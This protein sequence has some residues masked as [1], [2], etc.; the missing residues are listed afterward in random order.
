MAYDPTKT[1][2]VNALA[3]SLALDALTAD[4]DA[5]DAALISLAARVTLL[6]RGTPMPSPAPTPTPPAG[7][8]APTHSRVLIGANY[9][10]GASGQAGDAYNF[11]YWYDDVPLL[12]KLYAAG[13]RSIRFV[14]QL[15]RV[16]PVIGGPADPQQLAD[17][18]RIVD[19][20]IALGMEVKVDDHTYGD[21]YADTVRY[22][23]AAGWVAAFEAVWSKWKNV[24][25]FVCQL[26]TNE[27][28][29]SSIGDNRAFQHKCRSLLRAK[30]WGNVMI[31][32]GTSDYSS[33]QFWLRRG[34]DQWMVE[35]DAWD[36]LGRKKTRFEA[37]QYPVGY[38]DQP[39]YEGNWSDRY[40]NWLHSLNANDI[41]GYLGEF[42][43]YQFPQSAQMARDMVAYFEQFPNLRGA[44]VFVLTRATIVPNQALGAMDNAGTITQLPLLELLDTQRALTAPV[45][46]AA[47]IDSF[48][49]TPRAV[50]AV[51]TPFALKVTS[52][53]SD[54]LFVSDFDN[55]TPGNLA[56]VISPTGDKFE[57]NEDGT[58]CYGTF[59][60]IA[61]E[62]N[63][64]LIKMMGDQEVES[65]AKVTVTAAL[66]DLTVSPQTTQRGAYS[67]SVAGLRRGS[68]VETD[69][70]GFS[71][72]DGRLEG[73]FPDAGV[74][75]VRLIERNA[76]GTTPSKV[77]EVSVNVL[78]AA[79]TVTQDM[80]FFRETEPY[81]Q[82]GSFFD[83]PLKK[84]PNIF[85]LWGSGAQI[86]NSYL[87]IAGQ[88]GGYAALTVPAESND[89]MR[90]HTVS[91]PADGNYEIK[92]DSGSGQ[93]GPRIDKVL[94]IAVALTGVTGLTG[95]NWS[96]SI[97]NK[98]GQYGGPIDSLGHTVGILISTS[99]H[100]A[101]GGVLVYDE[102]DPRP[103]PA[104][105]LVHADIAGEA[106]VTIS[107]GVSFTGYGLL[108]FARA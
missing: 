34:D 62:V 98:S 6:E 82:A 21:Y 39:V 87:N 84:G 14:M 19:R 105:H 26:G 88:N 37:H 41:D 47:V 32:A 75:K 93:S 42:H 51:L 15:R 79:S 50:P 12:E 65:V 18:T 70:P 5:E 38:P 107:N 100:F 9:G 83:V 52:A 57:V 30:G 1:V 78:A 80:T 66:Q 96:K 73:I 40:Y 99:S 53:T 106:T 49:R 95:R 45:A 29:H 54:V 58:G 13:A 97:D 67:G 28:I 91:A 20:A 81:Y 4:Q 89:I 64:R 27:P 71:I 74:Q 48:K 63:L 33:A 72:V 44:D 2:S 16:V 55:T 31:M 24:D 35:A 36:P 108:D 86:G 22:Q 68:T 56:G 92:F 76:F 77:T 10:N 60:N 59:T 61:G 7:L 102:S 90:F 17:I 8:P 101:T 69:T 43:T 85:V 23:H 94:G 25:G 11:G 103:E 104:F 3:W 46:R